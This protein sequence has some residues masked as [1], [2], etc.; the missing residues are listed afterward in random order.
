M[1]QGIFIDNQDSDKQFAG[2]MST[3][4]PHGLQVSFKK[5]RE[6]MPLAQ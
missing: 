5:S 3:S 4:G 6:L 1:Y 2:L